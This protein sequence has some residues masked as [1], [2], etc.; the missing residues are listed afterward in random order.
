LQTKNES[1]EFLTNIRLFIKTPNP[2]QEFY[3]EV[4]ITLF[5]HQSWRKSKEIPATLLNE[6]K[7]Q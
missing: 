2:M 5:A 1:K 3:N 6:E 7:K 4:I